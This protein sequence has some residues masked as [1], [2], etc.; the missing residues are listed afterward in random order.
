MFW[1]KKKTISRHSLT[2]IVLLLVNN[3]QKETS[4][5]IFNTMYHL[6]N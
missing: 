6:L 2:K 4:I 3:F 1:L 5:S